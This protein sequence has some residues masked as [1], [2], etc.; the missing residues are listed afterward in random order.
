MTHSLL[1]VQLS[2]PL[3]TVDGCPVGVSLVGAHGAD[4]A[5][6]DLGIKL[7]T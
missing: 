5:L 2:L 3:M 7:T 1:G 6:I 4:E